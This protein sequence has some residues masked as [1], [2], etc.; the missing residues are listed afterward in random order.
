MKEIT[1]VKNK[2]VCEVK[3]LK[4]KK[5]RYET[6]TFLAEGYRN[7]CDSMKKAVPEMVF[8]ETDFEYPVPEFQNTYLIS[9]EIMKEISDT[10]TPQ[11]IAAVFSIPKEKEITSQKI[12]LLNGVSDPGNMGTIL[13]TALAAGFTDIFLDEKCADVYSPKV[14]RSAMSAVFSLNLIRTKSLEDAIAMLKQNGYLIYAAALTEDAISLYKTD[15]CEKSAL[16]FGSEANGI[17]PE[18]LALSDV[19]Y[20]IPMTKEIESLNVAVAAGI[21]MYELVRQCG[22]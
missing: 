1:S 17:V 18:L 4:Q 19:T 20:I 16:L 3:K 13:R 21:S 2:T 6:G 10:D 14:I 22:E 5:Y 8:L 9:K 11:G 12:L 15:F 7:V